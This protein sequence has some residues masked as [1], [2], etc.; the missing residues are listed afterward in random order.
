VRQRLQKI[1]KMNKC[2]RVRLMDLCFLF[3][4]IFSSYGAGWVLGVL[5]NS[6]PQ[7]ASLRLA[8]VY[9]F[10]TRTDKK[11]TK[12]RYFR[13]RECGLG[14]VHGYLITPS[15]VPEM[16]KNSLVHGG[17]ASVCKWRLR[18][19]RSSV[20]AEYVGE[21]TNEVCVSCNIGQRSVDLDSKI[22]I[23]LPIQKSQ[24]LDGGRWK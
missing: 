12:T 15:H 13:G 1:K 9:H 18:K 21:P 23:L 11:L 17:H 4:L 19:R 6:N 20:E 2:A 22:S 24:K 10:W 16:E 3:F 14:R 8:W 5:K 7:P